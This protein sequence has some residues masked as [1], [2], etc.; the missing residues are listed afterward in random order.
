MKFDQPVMLVGGGPLARGVMVQAKGYCGPVVAAD[1]GADTAL[2]FGLSLAGAIGDRDSISPESLHK[3]AGSYHYDSGQ[4]T[5]DFEKCLDLIKAPLILGVGFLGG[6]LDH[7]LAAINA[8]AK[9][10]QKPVVLLGEEDLVFCCPGRLELTLPV[11]AR[12]S[13]FPMEAVSGL[14]STGLA[15]PLAGLEMAPAG[16][17]GTSNI[18]D[19]P[20][21]VIKTTRG[22]LL[23]ILPRRFLPLVVA[24][25]GS[26]TKAL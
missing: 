8:L 7:E 15:Y 16:K 10:G 2:R 5:T 6:R 20:Q 14:H 24:A 21:Q 19:A 13:F 17:I 23:V 22:A 4:Q 18:T 26:D 12:I 9:F 25:L 11:G 3:L 1:G